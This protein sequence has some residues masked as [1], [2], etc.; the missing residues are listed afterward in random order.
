MGQCCPGIVKYY[1]QQVAEELSGEGIEVQIRRSGA[2]FTAINAG[3]DTDKEN[4]HLIE[5][6]DFEG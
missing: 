5:I 2:V 6:E 3:K 4:G 1:V